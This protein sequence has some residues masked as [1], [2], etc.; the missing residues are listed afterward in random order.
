MVA[1]PALPSLHGRPPGERQGLALPGLRRSE[2]R[3]ARQ[4]QQ[5]NR[6]NVPLQAP[7]GGSG[8]RLRY[9]VPLA[10]VIVLLIWQLYAAVSIAVMA[11]L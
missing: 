2:A 1:V 9:A 10:I 4:P 11:T 6:V 7:A 5:A 3:L 8:M